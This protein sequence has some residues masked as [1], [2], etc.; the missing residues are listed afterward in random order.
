MSVARAA[1]RKPLAF[2]IA[3]AVLLTLAI[4]FSGIATAN[5][6]DV[7]LQV[8]DETSTNPAGSYHTLTAT[9][10]VAA[11]DHA[12]EVDFEIDCT[13]G[14]SGATYTVLSGNQ[15]GA[16]TAA[17]AGGPVAAVD[18]P[19]D[20]DQTAGTVDDTRT[21]PELSCRIPIGSTTCQVSY[22]RNNNGEELIAGWLDRDYDTQGN[23][24]DNSD[25]AEGRDEATA[26]GN[27][28]EPDG[29]DIV[30]K[31]WFTS[32]TTGA[33]L[34]CD[35]EGTDDVDTQINPPG[36][37]EIYTCRAFTPGADNTTT[38]D[39]VALSG[40]VIDAENLFTLHGANGANDPDNSSAAGTAD[41]N[42]ACTT[43]SN[44][45][46]TFTL[47]AAEGETGTA[48][49][50]FWIDEDNDNAFS[51]ASTGTTDN[52]DGGQCDFE[53]ATADEPGGTNTND[54]TNRT[55]VVRKDWQ[56]P[57]ATS[58]DAEPER[59][60]NVKGTQHTVT[61]TVRDQFGNALAN[62]AVDFT[63]A[64]GS[65]N[66]G[67]LCDNVL[68][69]AQGVATCTYTDS[70][71][72]VGTEP[73]TDTI[74]VR[75]NGLVAADEGVDVVD[76]NLQDTVQKF[77]FTTLP[78]AASL[79]VDMLD[80]GT[81]NATNCDDTADS[82][83]DNPVNT[84]HDLCGIVYAGPG[85]TNPIAGANVN[86]VITGEGNFV[87]E[88]TTPGNTTAADRADDTDLGQSI[89]VTT[90]SSG[91]WVAHITSTDSG[92]TTVTA[93]SGNATD[94]GTK[95]WTALAARTLD[96][97]PETAENPPGTEHV[98]TCTAL[99]RFGNPTSDGGE[100]DTVQFGETG[101][102]RLES[103][104]NPA[105]DANG[106]VEA[107]FSTTETETGTQ[108]ITAALDS[109]DDDTTP[110]VRS[111][112]N[113]GTTDTDQND[114]CDALA[115]QTAA[116]ATDT[117]APAGVCADQLTKTWT[118]EPTPGDTECA[119]GVD[120]D[121]DG[122]IDFP[123]DAGCSSAED[124]SEI[125]ETPRP[126]RNRTG[127]ENVIVGTSGADV[128]TGTSENDIIC[129][130]GGDD[131]IAA[132][133]GA[134]LV[135]GNGGADSI[136]GGG[137]KDNLAGNGDNDTISGNRG[138]DAIKGQ[139]GGDTLKGNNGIDSIT[140]GKGADS[141]QGGDKGD[142]LKGSAGNDTLRGGKGRDLLNGGGGTDLCFGNAGRDRVRGCE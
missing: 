55:D 16:T 114:E 62:Q 91:V 124:D 138:N 35:D 7:T 83:D 67:T 111:D 3:L 61:A 128:L 71:T 66:V 108:T 44:G 130:A 133:G 100:D 105:L 81:P 82:T 117:G 2:T 87:N 113:E 26:P 34:D 51:T 18:A 102:G 37:S 115:G 43:G 126:C 135:V 39:D 60:S 85:A 20:G 41:Y 99:D 106:Q 59:D 65:A 75:T 58:L 139:R 24:T 36:Q 32:A 104:T 45:T 49:V 46:C 40:L 64:A 19:T 97:E 134:D 33:L 80:L 47:T 109:D 129:G 118:D 121:N 95:T 92:T 77:W 27:V 122:N 29:T 30:A 101:P 57:A 69:N 141:L 52:L 140:G 72:V 142:I 94:T 14:C 68:T 125:S 112:N 38:A 31:T 107:V 11:A 4:P 12:T 84:N 23:A 13:S 88:G 17:T 132:K 10:S 79:V 90:D 123:D 74:N 110:L 50:C 22:S 63:A 28:G 8:T 42:N 70:T 78:T 131:V 76:A 15:G 48:D 86:L 93:T 98:V 1:N 54:T 6:A 9:I 120:N 53:T 56:Q 103:A 73:E 25:A 21:S 119:D 137:G 116:G 89:S 5:H 136:K 127:G 96:C